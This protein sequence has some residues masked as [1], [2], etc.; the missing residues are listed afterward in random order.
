MTEQRPPG[1]RTNDKEALTPPLADGFDRRHLFG[2]DMIDAP[3]LDP[4]LDAV[5][6]PDPAPPGDDELAVLVTPNV[7]IMVDLDR[8]PDSE[9]AEVFR[10]ARYVLPDGMPIIVA[11]RLLGR[12]LSA[13]LT[14]SGLF[15]Q[16]WPRLVADRRSV[17]VLCSSDEI[18]ERLRGEHPDA[19][20]V[21][22]PMLDI[23]DA[24]QVERVVDELSERVAALDASYV[25]L[26]LGHPKDAVLAARL[27]D[28]WSGENQTERPLCLGLGGSF[29]MYAGLKKRA[30]RW[31][32]RTGLEWFYRFLQEPRRLFH[33]YFV[34]DVAFI[35]TV[36]RERKLLRAGK[37]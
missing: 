20:F 21:V 14:G 29:A 19:G 36:R 1:G 3:S 4:V 27:N 34:R 22:P 33:R 25:L 13:R 12:P 17:V 28:R 11:S 8:A 24:A 2:L 16:L 31:M 32:Q 23:D 6:A 5:L 37:R 35:G 30:P 26:G 7:D 9:A 10:R 18:V 15:E